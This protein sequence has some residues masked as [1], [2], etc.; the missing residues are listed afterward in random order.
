MPAIP[1]LYETHT[2]FRQHFQ[3]KEEEKEKSVLYSGKYGMGGA[4][5][6]HFL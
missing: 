1:W 4:G 5:I 2:G 6:Y 3:K